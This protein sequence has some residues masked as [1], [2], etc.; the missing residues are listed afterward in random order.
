MTYYLA[1][2]DERNP[3]Y[4]SILRSH[5]P[6]LTLEIR[7]ARKIGQRSTAE[8]QIHQWK[9]RKVPLTLFTA[10]ELREWHPK[11]LRRREEILNTEPGPVA[12]EGVVRWVLPGR[13][14]SGQPL[15]EYQ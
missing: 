14:P 6:Y 3:N 4:G 13:P 1:V 7:E 5:P 8:T 2:T 10:S 9:L 11:A 12:K 15:P